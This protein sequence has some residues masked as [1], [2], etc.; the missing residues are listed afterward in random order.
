MGRVR[1]ECQL[2][3]RCPLQTSG[4]YAF[5]AAT[6][7]LCAANQGVEASVLEDDGLVVIHQ[8]PAPLLPGTTQSSNAGNL[9]TFETDECG[10]LRRV[11]NHHSMF[12]TSAFG[13]DQDDPDDFDNDLGQ[14]P[15]PAWAQLQDWLYDHPDVGVLSQSVDKWCSDQEPMGEFNLWMQFYATWSHQS[16]R[17][18]PGKIADRLEGKIEIA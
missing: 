6:L 8:G 17:L 10:L 18:G 14:V 4:R 2:N 16:S 9:L 5:A 15:D 12:S 1:L 7:L 13:D 3:M 11:E